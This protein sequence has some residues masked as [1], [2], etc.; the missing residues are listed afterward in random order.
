M[1]PCLVIVNGKIDAVVLEPVLLL[2]DIDE[3]ANRAIAKPHRDFFGLFEAAGPS[4]KKN[5][6]S[7][8]D[9]NPRQHQK[10]D[11]LSLHSQVKSPPPTRYPAILIYFRA[12]RSRITHPYDT[13]RAG[14]IQPHPHV[15]GEVQFLTEIDCRRTG[16]LLPLCRS[17]GVHRI[18]K[19]LPGETRSG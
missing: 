10:N 1:G 13:R 17:L 18:A 5:R 6:Q 3:G 11:S 4:D 9:D 14:R 12:D 19:L 15:S 8:K 7:R 16:Q 2:G